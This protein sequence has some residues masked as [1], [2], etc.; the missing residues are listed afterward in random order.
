MLS[1]GA[2][3]GS[4][5]NA[6]WQM[7]ENK[8]AC[9]ASHPR[10][11][12]SAMAKVFVGMKVPR[13]EQKLEQIASLVSHE[14]KRAG[15]SVFLAYREIEERGLF[16]SFMPLIKENIHSSDLGIILYHPA[17]R[18]GLIEAGIAYSHSIPIWLCHKAGEKVSTTALE[19]ASEIFAYQ[20]LDNLSAKLSDSLKEWR[21]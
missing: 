21:P 3:S 20:T 18:G 14:I 15:H 19:C 12:F 9:D 16:Q 8:F 1:I 11:V 13:G 10:G 4:V 6:C 17:L 2:K 7:R 5:R